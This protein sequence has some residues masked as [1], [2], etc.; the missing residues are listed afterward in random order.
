MYDL[1]SSVVLQMGCSIKVYLTKV[2]GEWS[3][4]DDLCRE[5]IISLITN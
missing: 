4:W 2:N 5:V 1:V 3:Y